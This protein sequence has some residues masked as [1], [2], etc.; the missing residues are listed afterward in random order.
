MGER[1]PVGVPD[2]IA[3][4]YLVGAP[5]C[6]KRRMSLRA[7]A[8]A[9]MAPISP[10]GPLSPSLAPRVPAGRGKPAWV[11]ESVRLATTVG[12]LQ[13]DVFIEGSTLDRIL[14]YNLTEAPALPCPLRG[15]SAGSETTR[16]AKAARQIPMRSDCQS[17]PPPLRA[18]PGKRGRARPACLTA[19]ALTAGAQG[20]RGRNPFELTFRMSCDA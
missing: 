18:A 14:N 3:A 10:G 1:L 20:G 15:C 16:I 12:D 9:A 4:G 13:R 8:A 7:I 5:A 6:G 2:D 19:L 17:S 11:P